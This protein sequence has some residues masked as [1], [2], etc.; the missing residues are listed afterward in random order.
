MAKRKS[1]A[2][3][4]PAPRRKAP[5]IAPIASSAWDS[6]RDEILATVRDT[7]ALEA[8]TLADSAKRVEGADGEAYF[9]ALTLIASS[10]GR[11]VLTG[12][13]KS[14]LIARKIA[15]TMSS[16]GTP[17]TFLHPADALHGDLGVMSGDDVLIALG[18]SGESDELVHLIKAVRAM[19]ARIIALTNVAGSTLAREA[20]VSICVPLTKEACP[21]DLA[22]TASTTLAL[23]QGDALAM[24][25]MKLKDFKSEDFA[26]YHPGGRLGKRL[27][28][29]VTDLMIERAKCPVLHPA[30]ASVEDVITA[31]GEFGLGIVLFSQDGR[32][33][34]GVLTDG[35]IRRLLAR[36]RSKIFEQK[37]VDVLIRQPL[38]VSHDQMAV[39]AL[40]FMEDRPKPLNVVPIVGP[41]REIRGI[42]RLHEL[43]SVS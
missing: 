36:Y 42:V 11:V 34:D 39:A 40:K 19:G 4:K 9:R 1:P 6:R 30:R 29:R 5:R 7:L 32:T 2:R 13:G 17:A 23:A 21:L 10:S 26:R 35:D 25:L 27:L 3:R 41:G 18:K 31:L 8:K 16:T 33:L 12:V 20:D 43:L 37:V 14:G 15:A 38:T 28:L 22:P 24:A